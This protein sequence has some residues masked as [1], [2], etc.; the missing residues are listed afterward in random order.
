[1]T[2]TLDEPAVRPSTSPAQRLRAE[3]AA[4]RLSVSWFG[5]RKAL[6]DQQ[7]QRAAV[8]FDAQTNCLSAGK[9]LLDTRHPVYKALTA[10]RGRVVGYWRGVTVPFPDPGI[11]LIRQDAIESFESQMAG[12][13]DELNDA[14]QTLEERY[15]ELKEMAQQQLGSLFN[16]ADYPRHL[17][18]LFVVEWDYWI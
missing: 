18:G 4:I 17:R 13:R 11:R 1:M 16:A 9:R 14:V 5:V 12:F 8:A 6:T 3:M 2:V 10:I 7:K 15:D